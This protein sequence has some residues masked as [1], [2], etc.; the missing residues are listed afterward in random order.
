MPRRADPHSPVEIVTYDFWV[1]HGVPSPMGA[2]HTHTDIEIN[3][4]ESGHMRYLLGGGFVQVNA[5][6]LAVF[7][8][9]IPHRLIEAGPNTYT[10]WFTVPLPWALAWKLDAAFIQGLLHGRMLIENVGSEEE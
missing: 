4:V 9:S 10:H 6:G 3:L 7:W 1:M 2:F 8:A 5:G